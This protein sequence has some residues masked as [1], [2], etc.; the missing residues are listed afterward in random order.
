[1]DLQPCF[2]PRCD[3]L[4]HSRLLGYPCWH[5]TPDLFCVLKGPFLLI[6]SGLPPVFVAVRATT[7]DNWRS[8]LLGNLRVAVLSTMW[9][10]SSIRDPLGCEEMLEWTQVYTPHPP[11]PPH[12]LPPGIQPNG[13]GTCCYHVWTSGPASGEDGG[14]DGNMQGGKTPGKVSVP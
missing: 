1:M 5:L 2:Y 10:M 9:L 6:L 13:A 11:P 14:T 3:G 12:S 4:L 7:M 8:F